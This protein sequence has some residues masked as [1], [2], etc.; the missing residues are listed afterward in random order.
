MA[1]KKDEVQEV[2]YCTM[3]ISESC[4]KKKGSLNKSDFYVSTNPVFFKNGRMHICKTCMKEFCYV[5]GIFSIERFKS[6]LMI[7]DLP[8]LTKE[9]E[10]S[11][12]DKG[13]TIGVYIKNLYLNHKGKTN[14]DSDEYKEILEKEETEFELTADIINFWGNGFSKEDYEFLSNE[15]EELCSRFECE[16]YSQEMLFQEISHQRLVIKKNR[17]KG[18]SV[19]KEL[20]T[21]Q[22]LLGSANIKPVQE[23]GL[24]ASEQATFGTLIKK[25]ENEKPVPEPL[26][27]WT[28]ED[29]IKKYVIVWFLGHLSH[30]MGIKNQ[31]SDI[32]QE[33][34]NKFTV[35]LDEDELEK[36]EEGDS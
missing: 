28:T 1:T 36:E 19:D 32:Y 26:E 9:F 2:Y 10:S 24:N 20:K 33:E 8:F 21:L 3:Q 13:E 22:D 11:L 5:D 6:I 15:Y 34:I 12:A 17:Q 4:N 25:W 23:T 18:N 30:M 27:N 35:E 31:F 14:R 16:S 29:W 7:L